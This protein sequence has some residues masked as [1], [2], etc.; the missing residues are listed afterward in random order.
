MSA[1]HPL[2]RWIAD[3]SLNTKILLIV[4][5]LALVGLG[6]GVFAVQQMSDLSATAGQLY[7][8]SVVPT[9]DLEKIAVDVGTMRAT[10]L[11]HALS[12]STASK[13]K[14][15]EAMQTGDAQFDQD[16]AAYRVHAADPKLVDVLVSAWDTY[17]TVRD[18]QVLPASRRQDI[19]AVN[20]IRDTALTPA[21]TNAMAALSRLADAENAD[22]DAEAEGAHQ[23]NVSARTVTLA[24]LIVGLLLAA[25]IG[26]RVAR[27]IV[28][29]V[30]ALS[31][32]ID[33]IAGGDLTRQAA[34]DA[35]DEIGVMARQLDRAG[36]TLRDTIGQITGSSHTLAGSAQEMSTVNADIAANAEQTSRRADQV[37]SAAEQVSASVGTVAAASGE[38]S[39]SIRDIASSAPD[40]AAIARGAVD[41][42][43]SATT[44]VAKL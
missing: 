44:T 33:A 13:T 4:A 34:A 38:M 35:K 7:S 25:A 16:L 19:A 1:S 8:N 29:R 2:G 18:E 40:A 31:G 9:Q 26:L 22:A 14:Y 39:A 43:G 23:R 24:V 28:G 21:A 12:T 41:L 27:G 17:R 42:A 32:V 6:A 36:A 30:R 20:R 3:R 11:N 10:V 15:E 5:L 37:A